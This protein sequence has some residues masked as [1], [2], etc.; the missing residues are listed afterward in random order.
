MNEFQSNARPVAGG[1]LA[2]VRFAEDGQLEPMLGEGGKPIV[3]P[4]KV[5][6]LEAINAR[7]IGYMNGPA[8][9][10][11]GPTLSD[12]SEADVVF[13]KLGGVTEWAK[14]KGRGK[15]IPVERRA[16]A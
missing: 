16:R 14:Q 7:L 6:A 12:R 1:Y 8:Y 10:R 15:R 11:C 9:R 4:T 2:E 3:F 13:A 5:E